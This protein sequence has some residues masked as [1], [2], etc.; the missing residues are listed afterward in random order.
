MEFADWRKSY[1]EEDA[2]FDDERVGTVLREFQESVGETD[3]IIYGAGVIGKNMCRLL[4]ALELPVAHIV[5]RNYA[6]L[7]ERIFGMGGVKSPEEIRRYVD[8]DRKFLVLVSVNERLYGEIAGMLAEWGLP[9]SS[10]CSG[11]TIQK[12]LKSA[13]CA[14]NAREHRMFDIADCFECVHLENDC[15]AMLRHAKNMVG[16]RGTCNNVS[17]SFHTTGI[18]MGQRCTLKCKC[19]NES[20]PYFGEKREPFVPG[21][22]IARDLNRL[23]S[24]CDFLSYVEFVGGEPFLHPELEGIV[25][26]TLQIENLGILHVITNG[27]VVPNDGLCETLANQRVVVYISNYDNALKGKLRE[28][29]LETLE[30]LKKF[31]VIHKHGTNG[32]WLD[33]TDFDRT[34]DSGEEPGRRYGACVF[35]KCH[36]LYR[37]KLY[38]CP[39]HYGGVMLNHFSETEDVIDIHSMGSAEL[40]DALEALSHVPWLEA[41]KRCKLPFQ[42]RVVKAAEQL[43]KSDVALGNN[44]SYQ[45]GEWENEA[46]ENDS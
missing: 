21:A 34:D 27:T 20:L 43:G 38:G 6:N 9:E 42:A 19:C 4:Q 24:S 35:K 25:K 29:L 18:I 31:R 32:N 5:D 46:E 15:P 13:L 33:C 41:C 26:D 39:H 44:E 28:N 10:I 30:K 17:Q 3:L 40:A 36:R 37:G 2:I 23:A 16:Y 11:V 14:K 45:L 8:S 22:M 12:V 7:T 1:Y